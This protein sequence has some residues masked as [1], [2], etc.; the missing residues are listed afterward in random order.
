MKLGIF[1]THFGKILKFHD[2]PFGGSQV[3]PFGQTEG[4]TEDM[5][6]LLVAFC[7]F[8]KW[9]K[10]NE[11]VDPAFSKNLDILNLTVYPFYQASDF[12]SYVAPK[13]QRCI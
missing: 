13:M 10:F 9:W 4:M 8:A 2:N 6:K 3:V 1:W 5:T 12:T 7:D 11:T